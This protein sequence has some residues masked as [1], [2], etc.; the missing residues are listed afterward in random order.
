ML[1]VKMPKKNLHVC[2]YLEFL[3]FVSNINSTIVTLKVTSVLWKLLSSIP[4]R[5]SEGGWVRQPTANTDNLY[6]QRIRQVP[7]ITSNRDRNILKL[8]NSYIFIGVIK[9]YIFL[10]IK[11]LF[12]FFEESF[13]SLFLINF[14]KNLFALCLK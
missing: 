3:G 10:S 9:L 8:H 12:F 4:K 6:W 13:D 5:E 1:A 2:W 11:H 14:L 7:G